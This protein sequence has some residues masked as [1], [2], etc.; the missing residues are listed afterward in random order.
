MSSAAKCKTIKLLCATRRTVYAESLLSIIENYSKLLNTW[1]IV[2]ETAENQG[3][4]SR[5]SC[6]NGHLQFSLWCVLEG[7]WTKLAQLAGTQ[8]LAGMMVHIQ[9]ATRNE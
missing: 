9:E 8:K 3:S 7:M 4:N 1:D 2:G 6:I 5:S